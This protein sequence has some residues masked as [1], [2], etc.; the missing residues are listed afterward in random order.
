MAPWCFPDAHS[1][2]LEVTAD[3]EE[4]ARWLALRVTAPGPAAALRQACQ[5]FA[6]KWARV[7]PPGP[8]QLLGITYTAV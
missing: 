1:L 2:V 3:P 6:Q 7:V 5:R 8:R 4:D